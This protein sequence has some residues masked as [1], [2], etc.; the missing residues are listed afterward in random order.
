MYFLVLVIFLW[1]VP[2]LAHN[3][4]SLLW[5]AGISF[6]W[7]AAE[8]GRVATCHRWDAHVAR[9]AAPGPLAAWVWG[10]WVC[11]GCAGCAR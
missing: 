1:Q 4:R 10:E 8:G 5:D 3:Q 11:A 9:A 2:F 7:N 6:L